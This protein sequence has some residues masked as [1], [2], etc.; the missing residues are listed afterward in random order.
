[1][2]DMVSEK[3]AN[4]KVCEKWLGVQKKRKLL[5]CFFICV[6]SVGGKCLTQ[7]RAF[8]CS[9]NSDFKLH[10]I[11]VIIIVFLAWIVEQR[12]FFNDVN[13]ICDEPPR[14]NSAQPGHH[15]LWRVISQTAEKVWACN[16]NMLFKLAL[17]FSYRVLNKISRSVSK[18][19]FFCKTGFL[20]FSY[21]FAY[22]S[23]TYQYFQT[24]INS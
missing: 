3:Y 18:I 6:K 1:M 16:F 7:S 17:R 15:A 24:L 13:G 11:S 14:P 21:I 23:R 9:Q 10:D 20:H 8:F 12:V 4:I 2:F 19:I 22:N 5:K